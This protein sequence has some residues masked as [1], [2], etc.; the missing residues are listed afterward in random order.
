MIQTNDI[1]ELFFVA[2][3]IRKG[4]HELGKKVN[5][6]LTVSIGLVYQPAFREHSIDFLAEADKL[7]YEAKNNGKNKIVSMILEI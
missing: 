3:T 1:D 5:Y 2:E 7:L 4:V 6:E